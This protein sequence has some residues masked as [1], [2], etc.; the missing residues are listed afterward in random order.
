MA[1]GS[2]FPNHNID[3][4]PA[5]DT[6]E[7]AGGSLDQLLLSQTNAD[8]ISVIDGWIY[9]YVLVQVPFLFL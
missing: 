6:E 7:C 1:P 8:T 5:P 9:F 4:A 3:M 2:D